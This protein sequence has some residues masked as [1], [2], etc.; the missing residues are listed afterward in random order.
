LSI[1]SAE[2]IDQLQ[3]KLK[4]TKPV[5]AA[6]RAYYSFVQPELDSV[7][8]S[9]RSFIGLDVFNGTKDH[10]TLNESLGTIVKAIVLVPNIMFGADDVAP[11]YEA[12][13]SLSWN[14]LA[15]KSKDGTDRLDSFLAYFRP[16]E[17]KLEALGTMGLL[18]LTESFLSRDKE[19]LILDLITKHKMVERFVVSDVETSS[20]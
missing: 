10:L 20:D 15:L 4:L 16:L 9:I 17:E 13:A 6:L 11:T 7:T 2:Q 12:K 3:Y 19:R 1:P 18:V 14:L 8:D 5:E